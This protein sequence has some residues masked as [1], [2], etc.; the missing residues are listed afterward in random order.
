MKFK[1]IGIIFLGFIWAC[2]SGRKSVER[3]EGV[4]I[5]RFDR[6]LFA[7][8]HASPDV[9]SMDARDLVFFRLY[10]EGVLQ[11]GKADDP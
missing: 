4:E 6:H 3:G 8:N 5:V 7:L 11:L 10:V 9:Q 2:H 1:I